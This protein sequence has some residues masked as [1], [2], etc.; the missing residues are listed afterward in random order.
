[1]LVQWT[2]HSSQLV[3]K[4]N[5]LLSNHC[6]L[7]VTLAAEGRLIK[8]HKVILAASSKYFEVGNYILKL[9]FKIYYSGFVDLKS[10]CSA[11]NILQI[12]AIH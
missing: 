10:R 12:S 6:M 8:A 3:S 9:N 11:S 7:D 5:S 4:L 2:D 1:M